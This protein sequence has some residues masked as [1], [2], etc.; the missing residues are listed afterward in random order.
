[1]VLNICVVQ[2]QPIWT[3]TPAKAHCHGWAEK[4][5]LATFTIENAHAAGLPP[6]DTTIACCLQP[7]NPSRVHQSRQPAVETSRCQTLKA[8]HN[9]RLALAWKVNK[10]VER[11]EA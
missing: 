1:M 4:L 11:A 7:L 2:E 10:R 3:L 5:D 9:A 6:Y 8:R